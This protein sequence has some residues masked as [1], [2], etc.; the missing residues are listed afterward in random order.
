MEG[1]ASGDA[2]GGPEG[3]ARAAGG[4]DLFSYSEGMC[5]A[6]RS[7]VSDEAESTAPARFEAALPEPPAPEGPVRRVALGELV[8]FFASP[9]RWFFRERLGVRLELDDASLEDEE[10]F[11]LGNL[12]RYWLRS[13]ILDRMFAGVARGRDEALQRGAGRLPQ[14]TLGSIVH[15]RVWEEVEGLHRALDPH[16]AALEAP[17][18]EVDVEVDGWRVTGSVGNVGGEG[19]VWWRPGRL[20]ARDRIEIR[21]TQVALAA[22][23][24]GPSGALALSPREGRGEG[25]RICGAPRMPARISPSGSTPGGRG[26]PPRCPSFPRPRS[27]TRARSRRERVG[28]VPWREPAPRG[29]AARAPGAARGR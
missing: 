7:L 19:F 5:E 3:G 2:P 1:E 18:V 6:A 28:P 8:G 27:P 29:P 24:S 12:E 15:G 16:R 14:A 26:F 17:P 23:G 11:E 22:A 4:G 9:V 13:E 25:H 21:L 20:R 10:P